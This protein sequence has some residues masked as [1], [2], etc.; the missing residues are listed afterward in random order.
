MEINHHNRKFELDDAWWVE[1]G[2]GNFAPKRRAYRVDKEK[3]EGKEIL[4]I[5]IE[6][7]S[8]VKRDPSVNIFPNDCI[9]TGRTARARTVE[10]LQGFAGDA[11]MGPVEVYPES[12]DSKF[13]YEL[14]DGTHRLYCSLA[15]GFTHIP[16]TKFK[17]FDYGT[18]S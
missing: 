2:M 18:R 13:P 12:S 10:I 3:A 4:E 5:K 11:A 14:K 16:A 15:A 17:K 9:N 1:A 7:I 6:D 8:T